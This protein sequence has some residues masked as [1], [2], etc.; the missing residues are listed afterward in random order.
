MELKSLI[1]QTSSK[2]LCCVVVLVA[3]FITI[4]SVAAIVTPLSKYNHYA[5]YYVKLYW[6]EFVLPALQ[7]WFAVSLWRLRRWTRLVL[8]F[9]CWFLAIVFPP[10]ALTEPELDLPPLWNEQASLTENLI[11]SPLILAYT[12]AVIS[13]FVI[14]IL[15]IRKSDFQ[16]GL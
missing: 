7:L 15:Q 12:P 16:A 11:H 9:L 8:L 14:H 5:Y 10:I 2:V 3:G 6:P 1:P 13:L 4:I